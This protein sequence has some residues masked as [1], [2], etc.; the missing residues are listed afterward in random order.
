MFNVVT[1]QGHASEALVR[2]PG[3]DK[4]AFTG[5]TSTGR[6]IAEAAAPTLKRVSLE[7][8]GKAAAIVLDDAPLDRLVSTMTP[9]MMFNNGQMCLQP[10]RLLVPEHR[11]EEIVAAFVDAFRKVKVGSPTD[12]DTKVGPLINKKQQDRVLGLLQSTKEEGGVFRAR[13]WP[14]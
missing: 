14:P 1:G 13:R 11:K 6:K 5:S 7:L 2:H 12:P 9:A 3:V 8:G 4:I 10:S